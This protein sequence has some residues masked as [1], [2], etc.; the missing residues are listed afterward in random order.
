[1]S[2]KVRKIL[3]ILFVV[4]CIAAVIIIAFSGTELKDAWSTILSLKREWVI[5]DYKTDRGKTPQQ[6]KEEYSPQLQWYAR[7]VAELTGEKVREAALY[8]LDL[9]LLIPVGPEDGHF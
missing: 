6:L 1:M 7:A 3:S 4:L 2:P 8:S 9:D 5:L